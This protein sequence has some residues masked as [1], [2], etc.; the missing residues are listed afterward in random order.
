[1]PIRAALLDY[2]DTLATELDEPQPGASDMIAALRSRGLGIFVV[3]NNPAPR[4]GALF[5]ALGIQPHEFLTKQTVGGAKGTRRFVQYVCS[6][7]GASPQDLIYLGDSINDLTE[8]VN[9]CVV[10]FYA[11]WS[12]RPFE[13]GIP[14]AS[15]A[16][17]VDMVQQFFMKDHLWYARLDEKDARGR[18]ITLR[19]LLN[20]DT[21]IQSGVRELFKQDMQRPH[22]KYTLSEYL[23]LH[24]VAS[25]YREG[26]HLRFQAKRPIWCVYPG[27]AG[28]HNR[29]LQHIAGLMAR[30]F[31]NGWLPDLFLRHTPADKS[32]FL[33]NDNRTPTLENQ[34]QTIHLNHTHAARIR[35]KRVII[36]D[37]FT[38]DGFGF[39]TARNLLLNAGAADVVCIAAGK[40]GNY[41]NSFAP[42]P[43]VSW[44][45]FAPVTL[46][47]AH[48]EQ[49]FHRIVANPAALS[50]FG[51]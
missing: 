32:A 33:R 50:S 36:V 10:L 48:F 1:M 13:Y 25:L 21:A 40:Y 26:W 35:G 14:A 17:F 7:L 29:R 22:G 31:S 41:T 34:L 43:A 30:L 45:S 37:D 8:S 2:S 42:R 46:N 20:P 44:D 18:P 39:E 15:P 27:H 5:S 47:A 4:G 12:G 23:A 49:R 3:S 24:L 19:A 51:H 28:T 9:A 11:Q 38:T 6:Q 16:M